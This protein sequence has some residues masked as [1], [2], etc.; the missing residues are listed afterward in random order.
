MHIHEWA[1]QS[2]KTATCVTWLLS[3]RPTRDPFGWDRLLVVSDQS[4][5]ELVQQEIGSRVQVLSDGIGTTE[6]SLIMARIARVHPYAEGLDL[7]AWLSR[8]VVSVDSFHAFQRG[9]SGQVE[10]VID[11]LD[12]VLAMLFGRTPEFVTRTPD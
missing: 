8:Q 10:I 1:R 2:G 6:H 11:E 7:A 12:D 4:R 9:R 5:V 3:G